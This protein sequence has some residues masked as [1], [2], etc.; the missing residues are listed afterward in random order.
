VA[1]FGKAARDIARSDEAWH[2]PSL[3]VIHDDISGVARRDAMK[4]G[5]GSV[6]LD[7]A[8]PR[9]TWRGPAWPDTIHR[10]VWFTMMYPAW[11][12]VTR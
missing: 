1:R 7:L 11:L 4:R 3:G 9:V 2:D 8:K 6:W 5:A 10:S 12:D